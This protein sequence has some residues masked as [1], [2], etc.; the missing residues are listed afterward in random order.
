MEREASFM[1]LECLNRLS[2][3]SAGLRP[4]NLEIEDAVLKDLLE[5]HGGSGT[6]FRF[7]QGVTA[8]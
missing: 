1:E 3:H 4:L 7:A 8:I 6:R 2:T 5:G